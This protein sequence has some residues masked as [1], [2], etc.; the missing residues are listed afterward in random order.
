VTLSR[1]TLV[2]GVL[3][4]AA[5]SVAGCAD[6]EAVVL[7]ENR[8]TSKSREI[9]VDPYTPVAAP[10]ALVRPLDGILG[11]PVPLHP[12][13]PD[14]TTAYWRRPSG[15]PAGAPDGAH[16]TRVLLDAG[17]LCPLTLDGLFPTAGASPSAAAS[18]AL[19]PLDAQ[20]ASVAALPGAAASWRPERAAPDGPCPRNP[21]LDRP[22]TLASVVASL[23]AHLG[24]GTA[25]TAATTPAFPLDVLVLPLDL[26]PEGDVSSWLALATALR[27]ALPA[28]AAHP[29]A[30]A[31]PDLLLT[32]ADA[33]AFADPATAA[34]HPLSAFIAA[35]AAAGAPLDVFTYRTETAHAHGVARLT[36]ALRAALDDAGLTATALHLTAFSPAV[37]APWDTPDLVAARLGAFETAVRL[38]LQDLPVDA[39][40]SGRGPF[41]FTAGP[42]PDAAVPLAD[43]AA[44]L[45]PSAYFDLD[46]RPGPAFMTRFPL[47]QVAQEPRVRVLAGPDAADMAVLA[48]RPG[49]T[50]GTLRVVIA[51]ADV[52]SGAGSLTWQLR[53]PAFVPPAV[54]QVNFRLAVLDQKNHGLPSFFFSE[55]GTLTPDPRTGDVVLTR[56]LPIPGVH[57][58]ELERPTVP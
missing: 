13:L 32:D 46:G 1:V 29:I 6:D 33:D 15:A 17:G 37:D 19:A 56:E 16:V 44:R 2:I 24:E 10:F 9:V 23:A 54:R 18:Y 58:L 49:D 25:A 14:L 5:P 52:T 41:A 3:L 8:N 12:D 26:A 40:L 48:S 22:A 27:A 21:D 7:P 35:C 45:V 28:D 43:L 39:A 55:L 30:L 31:G 42:A 53:V 34:T 50:L 47:R 36:S 11:A 20:L 57:Y 38:F 4:V 51:N